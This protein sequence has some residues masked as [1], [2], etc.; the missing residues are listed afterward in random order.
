[1]DQ[2]TLLQFQDTYNEEFEGS[3]EIV[4]KLE[5]KEVK[6]RFLVPKRVDP[7]YDVVL[8]KK[9]AERYGLLRTDGKQ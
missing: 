7:P 9:D 5:S 1:M 2:E 8:G 6:T 4:W 3:I